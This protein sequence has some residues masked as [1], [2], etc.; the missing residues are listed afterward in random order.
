[1]LAHAIEVCDKSKQAGATAALSCC[2]ASCGT[3]FVPALLLAKLARSG[4]P[5]SSQLQL[6]QVAQPL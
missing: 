1:M 3:V 4:K 5:N 2:N 6:V